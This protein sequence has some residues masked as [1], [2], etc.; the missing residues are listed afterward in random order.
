MQL[1]VNHRKMRYHLA[2][3][4]RENCN[5]D[6]I[7]GEDRLLEVAS[8]EDPRLAHY[9]I[10]RWCGRRLQERAGQVVTRGYSG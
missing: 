10:C 4:Y 6:A 3:G 1:I 9:V 2:D 8:L 5:T 7:V